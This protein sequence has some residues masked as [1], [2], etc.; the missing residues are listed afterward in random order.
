MEDIIKTTLA[1]TYMPGKAPNNTMMNSGSPKYSLVPINGKRYESLDVSFQVPDNFNL[2]QTD[3]QFSPDPIMATSKIIPLV[4]EC[5]SDPVYVNY[6]LSYPVIV[7]VKDP[8]TQNVFQFALHSFI[9]DN[10]PGDWAASGYESDVQKQICTN[11][12]CAASISVK[13]SAGRSVDSASITFMGCSLGAT[14]S[15]GILAAPAPC[16][17]GPLQIYRQG[18][19]VYNKMESS[20]RLSGLAIT[21]TKVPAI[22]A[23][24]YEVIIQNL[25]LNGKYD[26]SP[27]AV[28]PI[29]AGNAVYMNFF[30]MVNV[31]SYQAGYSSA[32]GRISGMPAGYYVIGGT[33]LS[34][35]TELGS[36]LINYTLSES[37][38]GKDVYIYLPDE[39]GYQ[40]ITDAG[41]KAGATITLTNVLIKCGLGPISLSEVK[42]KGCS[43]GYNEV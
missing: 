33:L 28:I 38:D 3:F 25:S 9:K 29:E 10:K 13:D 4:G 2:D 30:D 12:Q 15:Q 8:L 16:G 32:G 21:L 7:R 36:F 17:L 37:L 35:G 1:Q 5:Q 43:V 34:K 6:F 24:F 11:P 42:F 23:H 40:S 14:N 19:D 31:K 20:D 26:I 39:L 22:N 18:Y 27:N 41:Q